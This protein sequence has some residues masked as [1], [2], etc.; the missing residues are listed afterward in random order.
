VRSS[1]RQSVLV[2]ALSGAAAL[3]GCDRSITSSEGLPPLEAVSTDS[4]AGTWT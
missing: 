1:L 2:V 3:F 4:D